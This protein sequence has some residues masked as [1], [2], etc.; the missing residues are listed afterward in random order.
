MYR[1]FS[2]PGASS[3]KSQVREPCEKAMLDF[4]HSWMSCI[5]SFTLYMV[6]ITANEC[7]PP[8]VLSVPHFKVVMNP[9]GSL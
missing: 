2:K 3:R 8:L 9:V 4:F 6:D 5:C 7:L 1:N